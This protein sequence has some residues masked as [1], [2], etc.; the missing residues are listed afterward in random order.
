[1]QTYFVAVLVC[2]F[3]LS[4][5][6]CFFYF[7]C[8]SRHY[9][10]PGTTA[11]LSWSLVL[12]V[13]LLF[14][15]CYSVE[16]SA[17]IIY[18]LNLVEDGDSC[19]ALCCNQALHLQWGTQNVS[20]LGTCL[21]LLVPCVPIISNSF[22]QLQN[23]ACEQA[24]RL[25]CNSWSSLWWAPGWSCHSFSGCMWILNPPCWPSSRQ[26]TGEFHMP[27]SFCD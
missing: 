1:M 21:V 20:T 14:T 4:A 12:Y 25:N 26:C 16:S 5:H 18:L 17:N 23:S 19:P 22:L 6:F 8:C 7:T 9:P 11:I 3:H 10:N 27:A 13:Y 2:I 15:L 24:I